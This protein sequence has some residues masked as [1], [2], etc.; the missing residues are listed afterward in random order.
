MKIIQVK[1]HKV[2]AL[3]VCSMSAQPN[4]QLPHF[5]RLWELPVLNG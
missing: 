1:M 5:A 3:T 4:F 2:L